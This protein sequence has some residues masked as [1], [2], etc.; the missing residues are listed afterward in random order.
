MSVIQA[1]DSNQILSTIA[2][3]GRITLEHHGYIQYSAIALNRK[4]N[5][6]NSQQQNGGV[7]QLF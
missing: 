2:L 7:I 6:I 4:H 5:Q 1:V 3:H